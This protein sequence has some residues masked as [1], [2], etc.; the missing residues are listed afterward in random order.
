[1]AV[2]KLIIEQVFCKF[3]F[4]GDI[5]SDR[6]TRFTAHW[7]K[8][9]MRQL[10]IHQSLSSAWHPESDG[11]T[12]V[13]NKLVE[14]TVRAH[15]NYMQSNWGELLCMVEFAINNSKH[16][17]TKFTPFFM[18]F[19]RH[20]LSPFARELVPLKE[21]HSDMPGVSFMTAQMEEVWAQALRNLIVARD[22]FKSYADAG[23]MEIEFKCG[24]M[25]ML[26]TKFLKP[27]FGAKKL[28]PRYMGPYAVSN[29]VNSV[30]YELSLPE[31]MKVHNVFHVSLLEPYVDNGKNR[32]P[33]PPVET[34]GIDFQEEFYL[35]KIIK[36]APFDTRCTKTRG[37]RDSVTRELNGSRN[38]ISTHRQILKYRC[39]WLDYPPEAASWVHEDAL[40]D[41]QDQVCAY[42]ANED[43]MA[44]TR[45]NRKRKMGIL[46]PEFNVGTS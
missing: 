11:S 30:S 35:D 16:S 31:Y 25:V 7:W 45:L 4:A 5:V 26:R 8:E 21:N 10:G 44:A 41:N 46:E 40:V 14:T 32:V 17:A 2:S 1:M 36:H 29:K 18:N 20:P 19:G 22:R 37:S 15:T 34:E 23:K 43:R 38:V 12:E 13:I 28:M 27:V 24:D 6:D 3:G 33:P 42:W 39:I 9:L